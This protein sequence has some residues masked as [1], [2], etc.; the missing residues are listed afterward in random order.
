MTPEEFSLLKNRD[1]VEFVDSDF[2]GRFLKQRTGYSSFYGSSF[3]RGDASVIKKDGKL[4]VAGRGLSG[5]HKI[6]Y[7]DGFIPVIPEML[8]SKMTK[9]QV[10]TTYKRKADKIDNAKLANLVAD[11]VISEL[12]KQSKIKLKK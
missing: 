6:E 7:P 1:V 12:K 10:D 11:K 8:K 5:A 4:F 9:K 3:I 2:M